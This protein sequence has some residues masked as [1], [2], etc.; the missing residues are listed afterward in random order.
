MVAKVDFTGA[1]LGPVLQQKVSSALLQHPDANV[2]KS[3]FTAATL[4][5]IAPAVVQSGNTAEAVRDGR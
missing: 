2:I 1:E 5:G 4:L 3:P